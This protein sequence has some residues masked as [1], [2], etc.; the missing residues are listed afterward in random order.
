MKSKEFKLKLI[1]ELRYT[2][3]VFHMD[4][5]E[6]NIR[7]PYCGDSK[8]SLNKARFYL[9]INPNDNNKIVMNC[10]NCPVKG[11]LDEEGLK[12]L[13]IT[14][15]F[16]INGIISLNKSKAKYIGEKI[17]NIQFDIVIPKVKMKDKSKIEYIQNRLGIK[18]N[19]EDIDKYKIITSLKDFIKEN[20]MYEIMCKPNML[21]YVD[22][23]FVGF[24]SFSNSHILFRNINDKESF[25][26]Y[27]Y[28]ISKKSTGQKVIYS[29]TNEVD[30]FTNEEIHINLSEGIMD[31]I[32]INKNL[33]R[34]MFD[35]DIAVGGA[36]YKSTINM[37]IGM[38]FIGDNIVLNIYSDNDIESTK[39][40]FYKKDL[41]IYKNIFKE[42]NIYY[43]KSYKDFGVTKDMINS[44]KY[45]I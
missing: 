34:H 3:R 12:L 29:I 38:G 21:D 8:K 39:L 26:W 41:S 40:S 37:L 15:S 6:I 27:K 5:T 16:L 43:N 28:P 45:K 9:K 31:I 24:L 33:D 20:T 36:F 1:E 44:I 30:L 18:L 22:R 10:F 32:S 13:G 23:Q 7:C 25:R 11:V 35:I 2:Q 17:E 4:G 14:D 19:K 42:I